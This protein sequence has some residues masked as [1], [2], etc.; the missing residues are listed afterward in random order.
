MRQRPP[1]QVRL[2]GTREGVTR[3]P[4]RR[5]A[6]PARKSPGV[7]PFCPGIAA[8]GLNRKARSVS[9]GSA[10]RLGG[11]NPLRFGRARSILQV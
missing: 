8:R 5:V 3:I 1:V 7:D 2:D 11:S 4:P 6:L 10:G 9:L